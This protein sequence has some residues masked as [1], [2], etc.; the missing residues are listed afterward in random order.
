MLRRCSVLFLLAASSL[1]ATAQENVAFRTPPEEIRRLVDAPL[2]PAV[3]VDPAGNRLVLL[4][5]PGY[6]SLQEL[7]EPELKL[8][9]LRINPKSHN[10]ARST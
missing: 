7:S 4:D 3:L 2:P 8:A 6:K 10:R 9:G 5:L 1:P